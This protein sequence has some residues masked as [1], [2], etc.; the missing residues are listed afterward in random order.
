MASHGEG[1]ARAPAD[2][3]IG[4]SAASDKAALARTVGVGAARGPD[5][6]DGELDP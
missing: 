5:S 4:F 3:V 2:Y 6:R 1:C